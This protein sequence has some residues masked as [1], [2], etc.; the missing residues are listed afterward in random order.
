MKKEKLLSRLIDIKRVVEFLPNTHLRCD[1][2]SDEEGRRLIDEGHLIIVHLPVSLPQNQRCKDVSH[3]TPH[4]LMITGYDDST[5]GWVV[6]DPSPK[7]ND[8]VLNQLRDESDRAFFRSNLY[9]PQDVSTVEKSNFLSKL[10]RVFDNFLKPL[11]GRGLIPQY[12]IVK[13]K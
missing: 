13:Q 10:N 1:E 3:F 12:I 11:G 2:L 5:Y 9:T 4:H 7:N 6:K 8:Y